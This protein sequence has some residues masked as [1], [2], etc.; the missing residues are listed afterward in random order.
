MTDPREHR[1]APSDAVEAEMPV[2][3][4]VLHREKVV[5]RS[6]ALIC[7]ALTIFFGATSVAY[8]SGWKP[9][10][11]LLVRLLTYAMVPLGVFTGLTRT[12]LRTAI[13]TREIHVAQGLSERRIALGNITACEVFTPGK[14]PV[15]A[16]LFSP[17]PARGVLVDWTDGPGKTRRTLIGSDDPAALAATI[18][19]ARGMFPRGLRVVPPAAG[20]QQAPVDEVSE[21]VE[22]VEE[23][24]AEG[25]S[26]ALG[27]SGG[28]SVLKG[29]G[30]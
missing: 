30:W 4:A 19:D 9:E 15:R 10:T 28:R 22:E 1:T 11:S 21:V 17:G 2:E 27:C 6:L 20:E 24:R 23:R 7:V 13:T 12:V 3:G 14:Q 8:L 29:S 26:K 16:E 25:R 5:A 18:E